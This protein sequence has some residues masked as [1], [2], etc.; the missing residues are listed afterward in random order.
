MSYNYWTAKELQFI[1]DNHD[2]MTVKQASQ[3][4]NRPSEPTRHQ[5]YRLGLKFK[6]DWEIKEYAYYKGDEL[7]GVGKVHELSKLSGISVENLLKYRFKCYQNRVNR[8]LVEL[9]DD[10]VV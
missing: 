1:M 3:Y 9:E 6:Q 10:N 5:A 4:L 7:V 8:V 2:K